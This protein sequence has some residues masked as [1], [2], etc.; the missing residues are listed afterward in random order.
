MAGSF[1][2]LQIKSIN[3]L[4]NEDE[5]VDGSCEIID[6]L[7]PNGLESNPKWSPA[8]QHLLKHNTNYSD[9][10]NVKE[11]VFHVQ[12][13]GLNT[14]FDHGSRAGTDYFIV[15]E[16][17]GTNDDIIVSTT[18]TSGSDKNKLTNIIKS[19]SNTG[20]H[21][22]PNMQAFSLR[23]D[24]QFIL[25][26]ESAE[27]DKHNPKTFN[28]DT[29]YMY[30]NRGD[31]VGQVI[32]PTFP[33]LTV[34]HSN[35]EFPLDTFEKAFPLG[36]YP[37]LLANRD[38]YV[39]VIF[40]YQTPSGQYIKQTAPYIH[41]IDGLIDGQFTT[42][43]AKL[44]CNDTATSNFDSVSLEKFRF[45]A[46]SKVD[47]LGGDVTT[48]ELGKI[49]GDTTNEKFVVTSP[50]SV[51]IQ[52]KYKVMSRT[53]SSANSSFGASFSIKIR[54][55]GFGDAFTSVFTETISPYNLYGVSAGS[56]FT[57][58]SDNITLDAGDYFCVLDDMTGFDALS[59]RVTEFNILVQANAANTVSQRNRVSTLQFTSN[60]TDTGDIFG[61]S[62][63]NAYTK[64]FSDSG[65]YYPTNELIGDT[66]RQV[67]H[68][69]IRDFYGLSGVHI[70]I[71]TPKDT[72][73]DAINEGTYYH[74]A[75]F[76]KTQT[77]GVLDFKDNESIIVTKR[78]MNNDPFSHHSLS[79]YNMRK[80]LNRVWLMGLV[81][82]F[83]P[84]QSSFY[85]GF[86]A[87]TSDGSTGTTNLNYNPDFD[88]NNDLL[89]QVFDKPLVC[90]ITVTINIDGKEFK[91]ISKTFL[92]GHVNGS[93]KISMIP[94]QIG[95]PDRRATKIEFIAT[96]GSGYQKF[97][98]ELEK[99]PFL[100]IAYNY[101]EDQR[102]T[103][104]TDGSISIPSP[105][106]ALT[107]NRKKLYEPGKVRVSS[108]DGYTFPLE[109]TYEVD[110][111]VI[112]CVD[113]IQEAAQSSFGRYPVTVF[114][115]NKIYGFEFGEGGVL[116]KKLMLITDDFGI[117]SR[118]AVTTLKGSI[119][120]L[121]K[122]SM[123]VMAGNNIQESHRPIEDIKEPSLS[124]ATSD[125]FAATIGTTDLFKGF[126][127][128]TGDPRLFSDPNKNRLYIF[129]G[130]N[131]YPLKP[132][133]IYDTRYNSYY[134][135]SQI[136]KDLFFV[137]STPYGFK[138]ESNTIKIYS[139]HDVDTTDTSTEI[140]LATGF[141]P[142]DSTFNYKKLLSSVLQGTFETKANEYCFITLQGKRST[143]NDPT[144]LIKITIGE[145]GVAVS[146]DGIYIKS[147]RGSYQSFRLLINGTAKISTKI[148]QTLFNYLPRNA[149]IKI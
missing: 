81:T 134:T 58:L 98:Y 64:A 8:Q 146:Q 47:S 57:A 22:S 147:N 33:T 95:Y 30:M 7:E 10:G 126:F 67:A 129:K 24:Q 19:D 133:L 127:T 91:R 101:S 94:N 18:T 17:E 45:N 102:L 79:A 3:T 90:Y 52:I 141:M 50:I 121:D 73:D 113:N 105:G 49:S 35:E 71:T 108:I 42:N 84:A 85:P 88:F 70:F 74:I 132:F 145:S 76:T 140:K 59:V 25:I 116:F 16:A 40:G 21:G 125:P 143:H 99:H 136:Y 53:F 66:G 148:G 43:F 11:K 144:T 63:S 6:N 46:T 100:N 56:E 13:E 27:T 114:C 69:K 92:K 82:D 142:F 115:A 2:Q 54:K 119:F 110:D 120:F 65:S 23:D 28:P 123:Y 93:T 80:A 39:G 72:F 97:E 103:T 48:G 109:Q 117:Y 20:F 41:K 26:N 112:S 139:L 68:N 62:S 86:L 124:V 9:S 137:N 78:V 60:G 44:T 34:S 38:R 107:A 111:M 32:P 96:H 37:G 130:G 89:T 36:D 29:S 149:K 31:T 77:D 15:C 118:D 55:D 122:N 128:G 75:N 14:D 135:S 87:H 83:A 61:H 5:Y 104:A 138:I 106:T 1:K 4:S 131:Y 12:R 51:Q